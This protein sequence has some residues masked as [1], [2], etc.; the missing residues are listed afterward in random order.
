MPVLKKLAQLDGAFELVIEDYN[1]S[2][3]TY[4]KTGKYLPD[5]GLDRLRK[6]DAIILGA[7]GAPGKQ[8]LPTI[9]YK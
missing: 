3:E 9:I 7:V 2:S 1:W 4:K 6:H 5:G 8:R